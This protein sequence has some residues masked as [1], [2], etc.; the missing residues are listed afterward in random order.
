MTIAVD[1]RDALLKDI[2]SLSLSKYVVEIADA[3][4]EGITVKGARAADAVAAT[5]VISA[6]HARFGEEFTVPFVSGVLN[7]LMS[8]VEPVK[9][10]P[11][12]SGPILP[13]SSSS[14]GAPAATAAA[15]AALIAASQQAQAA[16]LEQRE[17]DEKEEAARLLRL[18]PYL[19]VLGCLELAGL[20]QDNQIYAVVRDQSRDATTATL[21]KSMF[22]SKHSTD[23]PPCP[24]ASALFTA[25][26]ALCGQ[27][28]DTLANIPALVF[29]V[30]AFGSEITTAPTLSAATSTSASSVSKKGNGDDNDDDPF[31]DSDDDDSAENEAAET[32]FIY[33][34]KVLDMLKVLFGKASNLLTKQRE[35]LNQMAA[36]DN[37]MLISKGE[38]FES[39]KQRFESADKTHR[40][41][42]ANAQSLADAIGV[43]MITLAK[44]DTVTASPGATTVT[45]VVGGSQRLEDAFGPN[46]Q[47]ED[48]DTLEFYE[49]LEDLRQSVPVGLLE[50]GGRRKRPV[51]WKPTD[52]AGKPVDTAATGSVD[53]AADASTGNEDETAEEELILDAEKFAASLDIDGENE[54]NTAEGDGPSSTTASASDSAPVVSLANAPPKL[55]E[56]ISRLPDMVN[57]QRADEF[58][59]NFCYLNTRS[60]REQL[61]ATLMNV[62]RGR[63]DLLPYYARLL[64]TLSRPMPVFGESAVSILESVFKRTLRASAKRADLHV[65][66]R[67]VMAARFLGEL[68]KFRVVPAH[69]ALH[70]LKL[71]IDD[72]SVAALAALSAYLETCGRFVYKDPGMLGERARAMLE[73][74]QRKSKMLHRDSSIVLALENALEQCNP[75]AHQDASIV[76]AS[77]P[78][79]PLEAYLRRL[80]AR[81]LDARLPIE[82]RAAAIE[83]VVDRLRRVPWSSDRRARHTCL[84]LFTEVDAMRFDSMPLYAAVIASLRPYRPDFATAVIDSILELIRAGLERNRYTEN[85]SRV[86]AVQYL[87]ALYSVGLASAT[88]V[89]DT[90]YSVLSLG[91]PRGK[92]VPSYHPPLDPPGDFFR[93]RLACTLLNAAAVEPLRAVAA[94]SA[95]GGR[96]IA[97]LHAY[98]PHHSLLMD[99]TGKARL[100]AFML[101]LELYV[102]AKGSAMPQDVDFVLNSLLDSLEERGV[103]FTRY[104]SY[105]AAAQALD[106]LLAADFA[107]QRVVRVPTLAA[108]PS[109][110]SSTGLDDGGG[111]VDYDVVDETG[112]SEDASA[113]AISEAEMLAELMKR[114]IAEQALERERELE[115]QRLQQQ[116]DD[117]NKA[118]STAMTES[119]EGRRQER[120]QAFTM[121]IP[122]QVRRMLAAEPNQS[123]KDDTDDDDDD[124]LAEPD[125]NDDMNEYGSDNID[126]DADDDDG[127][128][129]NDEEEAAPMV[130]FQLLTKR[131]NK[132]A[133][134]TLAVPADSSIAAAATSGVDQQRLER[135]QLKELVLRSVDRMADESESR[136]KPV[137]NRNRI[138][139]QLSGGM[140]RGRPT[141]SGPSQAART[142]TVRGRG[143]GGPATR[144]RGISLSSHRTS[145]PQPHNLFD[146]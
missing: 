93:V 97:T 124:G 65:R 14:S 105:N 44:T 50:T 69:T 81:E 117:F 49:R 66:D 102:H 31:D 37:E 7:A 75:A 21:N 46:S 96:R 17:R 128:D 23:P 3:L 100:P 35:R 47:W 39:R 58:A 88:L 32:G 60:A 1:T 86:A 20:T 133:V 73:V 109:G 107:A 90:L 6:L 138:V 61:I 72:F 30:R 36:S 104:S 68:T 25:V 95:A 11:L 82:K 121:D 43:P 131:H 29:L 26:Q 53:A 122:L 87:G 94:S 113:A 129:N 16:A 34:D 63:T 99:P 9:L 24:Q 40:L 71:L 119:L 112:G 115:R 134:R 108:D 4:V 92:P 137:Q 120:R 116:E 64:A 118:F 125:L 123:G 52:G 70:I 42:F 84:R 132:L 41:L 10:T 83:R 18:R 106:E 15:N 101:F 85:R 98:Q 54:P 74:A 114:Q 76:N 55:G 145:Q 8:N 77:A 130:S 126:S 2:E 110:V 146:Y 140:G 127:D 19:R 103:V 78:M 5:E 111:R 141:A 79:P 48:Q 62:P 89:F 22:I 45:L 143:G 57:R 142:I 139:I 51:A 27:Q 59:V 12:A 80:L 38:L 67:C 33:G 56:L 28:N 136:N 91:H 144:G 13:T 135:E